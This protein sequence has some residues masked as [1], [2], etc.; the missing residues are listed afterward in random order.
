M[1]QQSVPVLVD[2][3]GG[4]EPPYPAWWIAQT[5]QLLMTLF[6]CGYRHNYSHLLDREPSDAAPAQVRQAEEYIEANAHR[7]VTLDDLA[8]VTGVSA[9]S[10]FSAFRKY[11][12]YSPFEFLSEVRS[13]QAGAPRGEADGPVSD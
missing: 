13:R 3:L 7:A 5:E 8:G 2:T 6:L 12:G 11:R 9:F 1:L 4:A 10:L